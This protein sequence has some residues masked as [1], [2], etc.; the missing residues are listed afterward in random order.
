MENG[1]TA[2][3][4]SVRNMA[5]NPRRFA[6]QILGSKGIAEIVTGYLPS[7][8]I[9]RD[10]SWSPGRSGKRWEDVSS[11]GI[12]KP[13]PHAGADRR[14]GNDVAVNDLID[15]I[16]KDRTPLCS[17]HEARTTVEMIMA[18]FESHRRGRP[19][20]APLETPEAPAV[21]A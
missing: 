3:F 4:A 6:L 15:A 18:V 1:A 16:E 11:A 19:V 17:I 10:S 2:S 7:V 8:K 9:L 5:G 14:R 20:E 13:E 21:A 12:G